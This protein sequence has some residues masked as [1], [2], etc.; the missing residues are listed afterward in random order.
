MGPAVGDI[1]SRQVLQY[2]SSSCLVDGR[3]KCHEHHK[4]YMKIDGHRI[5]KEENKE[6][7]RFAVIGTQGYEV[8]LLGKAEENRKKKLL[9]G[10]GSFKGSIED[11]RDSQDTILKSGLPLLVP[12]VSFNDKALSAS[13]Q[14]KKLAVFRLSF[15]RKSCDGTETSELCEY[16]SYKF[17]LS[18]MK[19]NSYLLIYICISLHDLV[20]ATAACSLIEIGSDINFFIQQSVL[21][22]STILKPNLLLRL[23]LYGRITKVVNHI[24]LQV[25][26]KD[27]CVIPKQDSLFLLA[28]ERSR[29]QDFGVRFLPQISNSVV[30]PISSMA[31]IHPLIGSFGNIHTSSYSVG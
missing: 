1:S 31:L 14:K 21:S 13:A 3:G 4:N 2:E 22:L 11:R 16:S 17:L 15:K 29:M 5:S 27:S 8:S 23:C 7:K 26:Q 12:S 30:L 20:H 9:N 24:Y 10:Y 18:E 19:S 25:L 28:A 6:S